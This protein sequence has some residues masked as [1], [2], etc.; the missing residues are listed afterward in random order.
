MMRPNVTEQLAGLRRILA[1]VVAPH[2]VDAYPA[3]VLAGVLAALDT[4]SRW[5]EIPDFLRW[6]SERCNSI[7]AAAGAPT[8]GFFG[9]PLDLDGLGQHQRAARGALEAAM[10][11]VLADGASRSAMV[12]Y[13]RERHVRFPLASTSVG[14]TVRE[15]GTDGAHTAR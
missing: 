3:D 6:D 4:L 14:R 11:V 7:L 13:F 1:E 9:D 12:D 5:D 15:E 10:P 2:V 8:I